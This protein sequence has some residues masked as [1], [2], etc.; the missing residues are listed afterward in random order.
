MLEINW[1]F[2]NHAAKAEQSGAVCVSLGELDN[3]FSIF[4]SKIYIFFFRLIGQNAW[5]SLCNNPPKSL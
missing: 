2:E 3:S 5:E 1:F 4:F